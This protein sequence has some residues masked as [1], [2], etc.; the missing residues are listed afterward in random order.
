MLHEMVSPCEPL[1]ASPPAIL[2]GAR[3]A[4]SANAV[5]RRLM[6]LEVSESGEVGR[7]GAIGKLA[8]PGSD[9][10]LVGVSR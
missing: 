6:P 8:L 2:D 5:D 3:V 7:R 9:E 10:T 4:R 1:V